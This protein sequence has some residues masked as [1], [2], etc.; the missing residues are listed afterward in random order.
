[1][2]TKIVLPLL[3]LSAALITPA[4][5]NWFSN[6]ILN[7]NRSPGSAPS[8]TPA[9]VR[10]DKQPPFVLR[11]PGATGTVAVARTQQL[12]PPAPTNRQ[13]VATAAP[14]R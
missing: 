2:N 10:Q 14:K 5:A 8:P 4:A 13:S 9:Q 11:D 7:I 3:I 6:P 12:P 1:M